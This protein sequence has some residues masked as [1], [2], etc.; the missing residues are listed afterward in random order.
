MLKFHMFVV[1]L[2]RFQQSKKTIEIVG[3]PICLKVNLH[4]VAVRRYRVV[5]RHSLRI[6]YK[7]L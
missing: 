4:G 5:S 7:F 3:G 2:F 6:R 1:L